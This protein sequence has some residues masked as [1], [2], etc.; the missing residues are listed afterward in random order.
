MSRIYILVAMLLVAILASGCASSASVKTAADADKSEKSEKSESKKLTLTEGEAKDVKVAGDRVELSLEEVSKTE[1]TLKL[2]DAEFTLKK[3]KSEKVDVDGD[4]E[5]DVKVKLVGT[6]KKDDVKQAK[7]EITEIEGKKAKKKDKKKAKVK[8]LK[9]KEGEEKKFKAGKD[10]EEH[11]VTVDEIDDDEVSFTVESTPESFKLKPGKS[12]KIDL[13]DDGTDD[14]LFK[15]KSVNGDK[16]KVEITEIKSA[17]SKAESHPDLFAVNSPQEFREFQLWLLLD[18]LLRNQGEDFVKGAQASF[19]TI[20][21]KEIR[22]PNEQEGVRKRFPLLWESFYFVTKSVG[23][24]IQKA[25]EEAFH[26]YLA[27]NGCTLD[28]EGEWQGCDALYA[29]IKAVAE[30][31]VGKASPGNLKTNAQKRLKVAIEDNEGGDSVIVFHSAIALIALE[32][33]EED[34]PWACLADNASLVGL[35]GCFLFEDGEKFCG[36]VTGFDKD[37]ITIEDDNGDEKTL[38]KDEMDDGEG[39][40]VLG[41]ADD[42]GTIKDKT[43]CFEWLSEE[44]EEKE[45]KCGLVMFEGDEVTIGEDED[46][47]EAVTLDWDV[48][49]KDVLLII[50]NDDVSAEELCNLLKERAKAAA[51]GAHEGVSLEGVYGWRHYFPSGDMTEGNSHRGAVRLMYAFGVPVALMLE[52]G[53]QGV[54]DGGFMPHHNETTGQDVHGYAAAGVAIVP[55]YDENLGARVGVSGTK[56]FN[57]GGGGVSAELCPLTLDVDGFVASACADVGWHTTGEE[58]GRNLSAP[59]MPN[60]DFSGFTFGAAGTAGIR[61]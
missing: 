59:Q 18:W 42:F 37:G 33:D 4:D 43:G 60:R 47:E 51:K 22:R 7:V 46:D 55:Q 41:D 19:E 20:I 26:K 23:D 57:E 56:L 38:T 12:Q 31:L 58:R 2:G 24:V 1:A 35:E 15:L 53:V 13:D 11:T 61:F 17:G 29:K 14:V 54:T 50:G 44:D 48:I 9:L 34:R 5:P 30:E 21:T 10:K 39:I 36:T 25:M 8:K 40:F 27:D 45:P 28:S 52:L 3:G 32:L 6:R 49:G 16:V